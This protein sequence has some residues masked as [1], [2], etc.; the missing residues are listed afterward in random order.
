MPPPSTSPSRYDSFP[1]APHWNEDRFPD[2]GDPED[3]PPSAFHPA[4]IPPSE[5]ERKGSDSG[6]V[7]RSASDPADGD[8]IA[9]PEVLGLGVDDRAVEEAVRCLSLERG[10]RVT[11]IDAGTDRAAVRS[12][13]VLVLDA[14][15]A[16]RLS[17]LASFFDL[18]TP[19][20]DFLLVRRQP[21]A[22]CTFEVY[23]YTRGQ[24][25]RLHDMLESLFPSDRPSRD[26]A[27]QILGTAPSIRLVRRQI[28]SI[29]RYPDV[30][31]LVLGETGTGKELVARA[32]HD[33]TAPREA[34]VALNCAAISEAL[35]ESELFGHERGAYTGAH[36]AHE[37][38]LE[39]AGAGTVFLDEIGE[40]PAQLQP[41]LLRAL[42]TRSFRRVGGR[43]DIP[44]RA[45]T[46][47]ATNR[48]LS[49]QNHDVLRSDLMFRL[50]GFTVAL[51]PFRTRL[52]DLMPIAQNFLRDFLKRH[53]RSRP[54]GFTSAAVAE[55]SQHS[56]PGNVRE[57]RAI[58]EQASILASGALIEAYDIQACLNEWQ[59]AKA[60]APAASAKAPEPTADGGLLDEVEREVVLRTLERFQGNLT[61]AAQELGIARSTLRYRLRRYATR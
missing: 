2:I 33:L 46:V 38:L 35:F 7:D 10:F 18:V 39:Q 36:T 24:L 34:F 1:P 19:E 30:S 42:E 31:V 9:G 32:I 20:R 28:R 29:A 16:S 15:R 60:A 61:K 48:S 44:L 59:C 5:L 17:V 23:S 26:A 47:S 13:D 8:C 40:M 14:A 58:V 3:E 52:G 53:G 21:S 57:L 11:S 49:R 54:M 55:L 27:D 50:A 45:R 56:W 43:R 22:D 4:A 6:G 41:K 51:Q 25:G 12:C 37:G